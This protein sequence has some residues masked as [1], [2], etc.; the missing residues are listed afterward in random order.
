MSF[1]SEF[2][3]MVHA[4][5]HKGERVSVANV[6][7]VGNLPEGEAAAAAITV[8][9]SIKMTPCLSRLRPEYLA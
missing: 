5:R 3:K 4:G 8:T 2:D 1:N 6:L 9:A 7:T